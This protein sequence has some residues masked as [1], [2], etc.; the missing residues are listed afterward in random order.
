MRA[1]NG[2]A[3]GTAFWPCFFMLHMISVRVGVF[4]QAESPSDAGEAA[5]RGLDGAIGANPR[6]ASGSARGRAAGCEKGAGISSCMHVATGGFGLGQ[7]RIFQG[8]GCPLKQ[9][10]KHGVNRQSWSRQQ[11]CL[12]PGV[13]LSC[14]HHVQ[15][16][17][18]FSWP[19]EANADFCLLRIL[20]FIFGF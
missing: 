14:V 19:V 1:N 5:G 6:A 3:N 9:S 17:T 16:Q 12:L 13:G 10:T 2:K 18:R 11:R 7:G 20:L 4:P 8:E 15:W